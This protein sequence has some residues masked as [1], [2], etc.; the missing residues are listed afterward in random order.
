ML[1][2]S[3]DRIPSIGKGLKITL[4]TLENDEERAK[5]F[6]ERIAPGV[7]LINTLAG[8]AHYEVLKTLTSCNCIPL[9]LLIR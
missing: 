5:G 2:L 7:K 8:T 3:F 6:L 9:N 1:Y 4:T